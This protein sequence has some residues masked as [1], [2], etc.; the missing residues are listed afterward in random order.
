MQEIGVHAPLVQHGLQMFY[1]VCCVVLNRYSGSKKC[2]NIYAISC[3]CLIVGRDA[4]V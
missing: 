4:G 2:P 1:H 3:N